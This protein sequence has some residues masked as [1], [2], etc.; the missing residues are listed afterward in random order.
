MSLPIVLA[1]DE[2]RGALIRVE[3]QLA[4]RYGGDYSVR[5]ERSAA[6]ALATLEG[7]RADEVPVALVLADQWLG[8]MTGAELLAKVRVLHAEA[9]R[10]LMIDW[11]AW[12][13]RPTAGAIFRGMTAAQWTTTSS[14]PGGRA[15]SSST[16]SS[17]SSCT[18]GRARARRASEI[19]LV[20]DPSSQRCYELRSVL[21]ATAS[22]SCSSP[23]LT[24][25][26]GRQ[27]LRQVGKEDET[28]PVAV[29]ATDRSSP[30]PR[31]SQLAAAFG[32]DT[33]L[34]GPRDF[35]VVV[36]GAGPAGPHRCGV[37]VV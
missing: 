7:L 4:R 29:C 22:R 27:T 32:V 12:G 19:T 11:G 28:A 35:D 16:A 13:H 1:V 33:E 25:P 23:A 10:G 6:T 20:A 34:D 9:K 5:S 24:S 8:G 30:T 18:S 14:S 2:D 21:D 36:V 3:E 31:A 37:R 26:E 15:T 17:P